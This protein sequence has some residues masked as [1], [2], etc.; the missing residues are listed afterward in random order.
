MRTFTASRRA[1][2]ATAVGVVL[3]LS[4][5]ACSRKTVMS[6]PDA[7]FGCSLQQFHGNLVAETGR[8]VFRSIQDNLPPDPVPLDVPAGWEVR[9]TDGGQFE[10]V[11]ATGRVRVTT[12]TQIILM[13]DGDPDSP[14]V[15]DDGAF[16]VCDAV[17]WPTDLDAGD[18]P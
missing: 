17:P 3:A 13:T 12:G 11:D 15:N 2:V 18:A 14:T 9:A 10:V 7:V 6:A 4:L 16:V 1:V 8:P 5:V